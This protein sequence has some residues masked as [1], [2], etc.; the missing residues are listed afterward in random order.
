M[1]RCDTN[2]RV[3]YKRT[4][5]L[6]PSFFSFRVTSDNVYPLPLTTSHGRTGSRLPAIVPYDFPLRNPLTGPQVT[7]CL[8]PSRRVHVTRTCRA[9][10]SFRSEQ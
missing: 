8:L 4:R 3:G 1:E 2:M 6:F 10:H 9:G 5:G 7:P